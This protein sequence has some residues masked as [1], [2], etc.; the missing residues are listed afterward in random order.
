[1]KAIKYHPSFTGRLRNAE[2]YDLYNVIDKHLESLEE[3]PAAL[4]P[5][6]NAFRKAFAKEDLLYKDYQ[7]QEDTRAVRI[8]CFE[9]KNAYMA[10][11][12]LIEAATYSHLPGVKTAGRKLMNILKNYDRFYDVPMNEASALGVNLAQDLKLPQYAA[13]LEQLPG[14]TEALTYF[15]RINEYFIERYTLRAVNVEE[16]RNLGNLHRARLSTD[17]AFQSLVLTVNVLYLT[18]ESLPT[19][20]PAQGARLS[21]LITF[22]NSYLRQHKEILMR[23]NPK[24]HLSP[25][26]E[27]Q[28]SVSPS[29]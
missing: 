5:A 13:A 2:H 17:A 12:K 6:W 3:K 27:N 10:L 9:R 16:K 1:M 18:N 14:V 19:P 22:V 20:D 29:T 21:E 4:L 15:I 25:D 23:R 11:K 8:A 26:A 24:Y 7:R 28:L